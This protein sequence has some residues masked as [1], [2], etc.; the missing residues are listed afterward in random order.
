[1]TLTRPSEAA[2][3]P[4]PA[5]V[6][7]VVPTFRE[8][9]NLPE[10]ID[11]VARL[12]ERTSREVE[13]VI[14]DDDSRDGTPEIVAASGHPWLRL[15]TRTGE[16]GLA[17]AVVAGLMSASN[18]LLVV[19]DADGS[20]DVGDVPRLV[21]ALDAG[22]GM[23]VGSRYVAGGSTD[24]EWGLAR[25]VNSKVATLLARPLTRVKDPMSGFLAIRRDVLAACSTLD[26]VGYK[27]G[28]E[29][30]VKSRCT[31]VREVPIHFSLRRHGHS[32]LSMAEQMRYCEHVRRLMAF[33]RPACS[34]L[35]GAVFDLL[36]YTLPLAG[37]L[38]LGIALPGAIALAAIVGV[39]V[40][41]ATS[42]VTGV[43]PRSPGRRRR[44]W[45]GYGLMIVA[46]MGGGWLAGLVV[47]LDRFRTVAVLGAAGLGSVGDFVWRLPREQTRERSF[48]A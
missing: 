36:T 4:T 14:V 24:A 7:I 28:L 35:A 6:S 45:L 37:F 26:P 39:T 9:E 40:L 23:A 19:M 44:L 17:S 33:R 38:M 31:D 25:L 18:D 29:L 13:L 22:A 5:P 42:R 10:L 46:S 30:L 11:R 21:D 41:L 16:R 3:S 27:I 20:H 8:A 12:R 1:V 32:K 34:S 47:S 43:R 2:H 48:V 15:I